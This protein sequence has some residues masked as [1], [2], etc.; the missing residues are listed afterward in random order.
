MT[1]IYLTRVFEQKVSEMPQ[2]FRKKPIVVEAYRWFKNGDH[3][4]DGTEVFS[5][6][7]FQGQRFEG[8]IVRYYRHPD[9]DGYYVCRTCAHQMKDHG[10]IDT[11]EG[12]HVVCPGDWIIEG[13]KG[14]FYPCKHDIF[15]ETYESADTVPS[16]LTIK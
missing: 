13:V 15:M 11:L 16:K 6:G 10:W 9:V 12:G 7:P 1:S 5:N 14:E 8:K 2:K 3:P 4:L